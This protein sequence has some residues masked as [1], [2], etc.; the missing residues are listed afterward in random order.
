MLERTE[1]ESFPQG[2]TAP[3]ERGGRCGSFIVDR[4]GTILGF[5]VG[6]EALTGWPA[7]EVVGRNKEATQ[8]PVA[9]GSGKRGGTVVPLYSG[10]IPLP[11]SSQRLELRVFLPDGRSMDVD[12]VAERLQGGGERI[13]VSVQRVLALWSDSEAPNERE[14]GDALTGLVGA[15]AFLERLADGMRCAAAV[16]RPVAVVLADIDHLRRINDRLGHAAGGEVLRKV[17]G[18]LRASVSDEDSVARLKD[19]DF[20]LLL[21]G[22]GRGEARQ[23]A[24]R[25]RSTV[26]R[27]R[28]FGYR[29]DE[30]PTPVTLSLGAASFPADADNA[31]EQLERAREALGEARSFGRNRVWCY[32]RRPRVPVHVPVYFDGIDVALLGFSLD[33]SPSGIFVQ[34][35]TSIDIGMRCALAFPLPGNHENIHVI[36]RVVRTVPPQAAP[37][38]ESRVPGMG[39]E[40]ER[41]GPTDRGVLERF[42]H[43]HEPSSLRPENGMLSV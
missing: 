6:M 2:R 42:L 37:L 8:A 12:A 16:G 20:A 35:R 4:K 15:D 1:N 36:G 29:D 10:T 33:L 11:T 7:V 3:R 41:L 5:D 32:L 28:F 30:N 39:I 9:S 38:G 27:F 24:A 25:L 18:I 13:A 17:A 19:D 21:V 34:T 22:A 26:E 43:L 31:V 40:F 23:I 14:G